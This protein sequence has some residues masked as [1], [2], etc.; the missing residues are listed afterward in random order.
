MTVLYA[1]Y[2]HSVSSANLWRESPSAFIWRYGMQRWGKDNARTWMGKAAEA[3]Y[4]NVLLHGGTAD[5]A[6]ADAVVRFYGLSEGEDS[7]HAEYAGWI[8]RAFVEQTSPDWGKF[9]QHNPSRPV[10]S[11]E[12]DHEISFKPDFI[13]ENALIDTKATLQIKSDPSMS[14]K[15]QIAAY[16]KQWG[17]PGVIFYA[18]PTKKQGM[19]IA[20]KHAFYEQD[21][22]ERDRLW[23]GLMMD[24]RQIEAW[25]N[26]FES[27]TDAIRHTA[28]NT[29]SFYWE[30]D[31][32]EEATNL[33]LKE[34]AA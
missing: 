12:L 28:L 32:V 3:A 23:A 7:E 9:V 29:D 19:P 17:I 2:R 33:W 31:D 11:G 8:A 6:Q 34:W 4:A 26:R 13:F 25:S 10:H 1:R 15:R 30:E 5:D 14:H 22:E 18:S 20:Y 24:W 21:V 27:V 16:S